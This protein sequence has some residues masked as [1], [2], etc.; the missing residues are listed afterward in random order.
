MLKAPVFVGVKNYI[1]MFTNDLTFYQSLKVTILYTLITIPIKLA[2]AL[3]IAMILNVSIRGI[4]LFRTIFYLPSI[5]GGSVAI[6][7][8]WRFIFMRDGLFNQFL[9]TL[10]LPTADWLGNPDLT[11][12]TI[13]MLAV[14][15]FGSSMVIF[16]AGLK[17]IP[18]SLYEASTIDGA[19][20]PRKFISITLPML[21]PVILFNLVIQTIYALQEFTSVFIVTKGGPVKATYLYALMLYDEGFGY[22]RMGYASALA[23]IF[24]I[25]IMAITLI[26][27]KFFAKRTYYGEGG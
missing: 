9:S 6:A 24:F 5:L 10:S 21:S 13:S 19:S 4:N 14:W 8:V 16:L 26:I 11:L 12:G 25:I 20:R 17:Q 7:I 18:V 2:F 15:Q 1:K 22:F 3:L 23:W 27:F